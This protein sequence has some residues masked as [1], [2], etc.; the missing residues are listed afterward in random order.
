M[1]K[2][3]A[4][5]FATAAGFVILDAGWLTLVGPRLYQPIRDGILSGQVRL[6]PAVIFYVVYIAGLTWLVVR[7]ALASGRWQ[8][9]LVGGAI[10]GLAAYGT[11]ALTN[12]AVMR[13]W[14]PAITVADMAWGAVASSA[15]ALIGYLVARAVTK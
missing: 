5:Y 14:T 13:V 1:P 12:H 7:P 4:A 6:V 11:Y 8:D 15:A 3:I 10:F 9:A 2:L